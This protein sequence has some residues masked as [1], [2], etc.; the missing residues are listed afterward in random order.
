MGTVNLQITVKYSRN[1][2]MQQLTSVKTFNTNVHKNTV[3]KHKTR[4]YDFGEREIV[5]Y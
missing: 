5:K 2:T 3:N 4:F 1:I